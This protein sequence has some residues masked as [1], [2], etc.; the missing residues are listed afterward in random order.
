MFCQDV[1]GVHSNDPWRQAPGLLRARSTICAMDSLSDQS[2]CFVIRR[3]LTPRNSFEATPMFEFSSQQASMKIPQ[4]GNLPLG[5][6]RLGFIASA[7]TAVTLAAP[8][9]LMR[10]AS[11]LG[12]SVRASSQTSSRISQAKPVLT[13]QKVPCRSRAIWQNGHHIP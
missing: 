12:I 4:P 7:A 5:R 6:V 10:V 1:Q 13:F 9:A 11:P 8:A 2:N 3:T